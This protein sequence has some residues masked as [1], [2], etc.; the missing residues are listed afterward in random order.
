[1]NSTIMNKYQGRRNMIRRK[2]SNLKFK[3]ILKVCNPK[4]KK[5]KNISI[6]SKIYVKIL[7]F[8]QDQ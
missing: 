1:M 4:P 8:K 6:K 7:K 2:K 5:H 3:Q